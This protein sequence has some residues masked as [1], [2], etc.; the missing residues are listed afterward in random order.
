MSISQLKSEESTLRQS[1]VKL[2]HLEKERPLGYPG[3]VTKRGG[4]GGR[5]SSCSQT[6][7]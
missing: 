5:E 2:L 7:P 1:L 6:Y 4:A 3:R